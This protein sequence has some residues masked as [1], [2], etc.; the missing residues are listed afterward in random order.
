MGKLYHG[1][2]MHIFRAGV[3]CEFQQKMMLELS[4]MEKDIQRLEE[5]EKKTEVF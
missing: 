5:A 1:F 4:A 3:L 2:K